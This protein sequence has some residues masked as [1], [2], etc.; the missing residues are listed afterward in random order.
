[1]HAGALMDSALELY[2]AQPAL[3]YLATLA[4]K[5]DLIP[6]LYLCFPL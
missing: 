5:K 6:C 4:S 1:M 2:T 3:L